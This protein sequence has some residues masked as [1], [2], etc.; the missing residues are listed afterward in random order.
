SFLTSLDMW[1]EMISGTEADQL[2]KYISRDYIGFDSSEQLK[3]V[4]RAWIDESLTPA[5]GSDNRLADLFYKVDMG[6]PS[7][8]T[9]KNSWVSEQTGGLIPYT[10]SNFSKSNLMDLMSVVSFS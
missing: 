3:L 7:S 2:K 8:T 5:N 4:N 10:P 1:R 6:D 9:T